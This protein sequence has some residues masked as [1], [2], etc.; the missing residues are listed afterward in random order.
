MKKIL[1]TTDL[2]SSSKAAMRFAIQLASQ[3]DIALTFLHV[4]HIPRPTTWTE[5]AYTAHEK[6]EIGAK[7][8]ALDHFVE[9]VYKSR[10][11]DPF[12]YS[13][14]I[15]NSPFTDSTILDYAT[16][17][18]FDYICIST[19]GAGLLDKLFGTTTSNL[20]NQS[21]IP[22]IIVPGHYRSTKLTNVL[23]ASD[24]T[25]L[26]ELIRVVDFARPVSAAVRLLHFSEPLEPIIDP[27]IIRVAVQKQTDYPVAVQLTPRHVVKTL[28]EDIEGAMNAHKPSVLIMFTT[29]QEGFFSQLFMSGNSIDYSFLT[30][31]PLLVFSKA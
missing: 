7:R 18:D 25:R 5:A 23:Y 2:S 30:T 27:D 26:D 11:T 14:V 17:H 20:I 6:S 22:V 8:E 24:L 29:Q 9:A 16:D 3:C 21:K 12:D 28:T 13:C 4:S 10:N 15:K 1:V 31:V 19:H